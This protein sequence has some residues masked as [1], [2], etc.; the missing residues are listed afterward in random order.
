M[1]RH[2]CAHFHFSLGKYLFMIGKPVP[3]LKEIKWASQIGYDDTMIHSDIALL[4]IDQGFF[5]EARSELEKALI[6]YDD[7]GGVYTNWGHYY[8]ELRYYDEAI[9]SFRQAI[10]LDPDN[11]DYY[12]NLGLALYQA[13]RN[14]EAAAALHQSLSMNRD[15]LK[16][17]TFLQKHPE[18]GDR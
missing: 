2:V 9:K 15:Q 1:N 12:N 3:G 18:P 16:V 14:D 10:K 5:E 4:L 13:G 11:F 8:Y 17:E 6:Y 7:L